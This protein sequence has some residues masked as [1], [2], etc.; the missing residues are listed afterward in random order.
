MKQKIVYLLLFLCSIAYA[1][2]PT[3]GLQAM[4]EFT[5][6]SLVDPVNSN[7]FT[8]NGTALTQVNDR[9]N[10]NTKAISLNGDYLSRVYFQHNQHITYSF[11]VKTTTDTF[12]Y[13]TIIDD[14]QKNGGSNNFASTQKGYSIMLYRGKIIADVRMQHRAKFTSAQAY[15]GTTATSGFIADGNWHHVVVRFRGYKAP[16]TI[17]YY[18]LASVHIDGT[19]HEENDQFYGN[20]GTLPIFEVPGNIV[21]GNNKNNTLNTNLKYT[22]NI[23]D[24]LIYNRELSAQEILNIRDVGGF[25]L[26]PS[27]SLFSNTAITETSITLATPATSHDIAYHKSSEPFSNATIVTQVLNNTT[28]NGLDPSTPYSFY[29]RKP[30][31]ATGTTGWSAVKTIRTAGNI[32]VNHAATGNNDGSSWANAYT[33]LRSSI[34]I[35]GPD[36]PIWVATGTYKPDAT[37]RTIYFNIN[38]ENIKI[39]GGFAGTETAISQRIIGSNETILSG[40]LQGND[41]NVTDYPSNYANSTRNTD[42]SYHI[43]N[44]ASTGNNLLL[45]G[46]TISNAHNNLSGSEKGG[47]IIKD[48]T[49]SKLTLKNCIIKDNVSRNDNAGLIA[50]FELNNIASTRGTLIIDNCKFINNMSRWGSGIY[51]FIRGNTNVDITVTNSL[52]ENNLVADL[53]SSLKGI[54]GSASWFRVVD[55]GSNVTL[56]LTNNTYVNNID[57][58]TDNLNNLNRAVVAISRPSG[59]TGVFNA[60]LNNSIFWGNSTT[61]G[62]TTRSITDLYSTS[63]SSVVV[64]NSIDEL[65][66]NDDSITS[67]T[68][69]NNS[70]PLFT[71]TTDFTLQIGSPAIDTGDNAK[72]VGNTDLLG[73][74]RVFNT[75]V[76]MGAFEY[77]SPIYVERTLTINATNGTVATN[78]NPNNNGA[79]AD[80]TVVTLTA[81]PDTGYQFDGWSGALAGTTNPSNITMDADKTVTATFSLIPAPIPTF[82]NSPT[83][84]SGAYTATIN[85]SNAVS[86]FDISDI[87][88]TGATLSNFTAVSG[89]EYTVVVTPTSIC[90]STVTLQVP[91]NVAQDSNSVNNTVSTVATINTVDNVNPSIIVQNFTLQ[92]DTN[93]QG[94]LTVASIDNGSSDNCAIATR[95]LDKT[96]FTCADL[97]ANT[98]KLT[99]VDTSGNTS[100]ATATVT[101]VDNIAPSVVTQ[102][103]TVQLGTN[104]QVNINTADI[105]NGSSDNCGISTMSLNT[106]TFTCNNLGA[107][108]V[109][110]TVEDA[111]GNTNTATAVVTVNPNPTA[112]LAAVTQ[113]I[114]VQLDVNGN[115]TITPQQVDNGSGSGCNSNPT[116]SLDKTIFTCADLGT[117]TVTLTATD[118]GNSATATA[119]VTIID[120]I[121]PTIIAQDYTLE[122]D[123]N[124]QGTLTVATIDNGSSDNCA[125]ATKTLDKTSFTCADLGTNT[126]KLTVVDTSGNTSDATATVTVV[127]NIAPSVVTQNITVQLGTNGQVNINTADINNGSSDNCGI[128]SMS[129]NTTTFTCNNLGTN[130][131]ILTV[132]DASGNTNTATAVV[133]VNP[134]P[135]AQLAAVTQNITVQLDV[136]GNATITPQQVDNGSGSGCN[137]NPTLSLDKTIFTCADLGTNTVSLTATDGGNS[138]TATAT[139]T[140]ID[141]IAPTIVAQDY[142]LELDA[143]GQGTLTVAFID[144]GSSD[145]CAIATRALDKTSFTCTD[146]GTNTVKLTVV[147][148]SG[149]TSDTTATVTVV[150]NIAPAVIAQNITVQLGANGQVSIN[151]TDI[152]NG[153]SDN[154]GISSMS[155]NTSTFTC[156]NLGANNVVLT[157]EDASGNTNTATAVVT[158]NSNPN[159]QLAAITQNITV[160][161]DANGNAT[162]KPQQIDNGSGSGCNSSPT[163]SLDVSTFS[164]ANIGTN[165]VTLTANDGTTSETATAIVTVEDK[166][167]PTVTTKDVTVTLDVNGQ[168]SITVTDIDNGSADNCGID[169]RTLDVTNFTC[170]D[171]AQHSYFNYC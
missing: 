47:A 73:N 42:N 126:V 25:C 161:L 171:V 94:T 93:G 63:V 102:N 163:L 89:T 140:I 64:N 34:L 38:K 18:G 59:V 98:V 58:G 152:N 17:N 1:Q 88:V 45:D 44:I 56:N 114:T 142:T 155:L 30:C 39:Y 87:Q 62:A 103:I 107:N 167:A 54:S 112:Q 170:A 71:S 101:V 40:D 106:T 141:T 169:T 24:I 65:N 49:I 151:T 110:L 100:D 8:Q 109:T 29:L 120:T 138:A 86:G 79:Y 61:G 11:W 52:F 4:Y 75:T 48:K 156:N 41:T 66:F 35:S 129:L 78:P 168:G 81:T 82:A 105:N 134:N 27:N 117:N 16:G 72:V 116:L 14:S 154:C 28:I 122:L 80:G 159:A 83:N 113:N 76:D 158:V 148:T 157:V 121:A 97:G 20:A 31:V 23:D 33:D 5:N 162:I 26:A 165:T 118:G 108:N 69:T 74:N 12:E 133:T 46:L 50:E 125:I 124:G 115:A 99:V 137:S 147:D 153:S 143:N 15:S 164:C 53:S 123:A 104:G 166:T 68:N 6:G 60:Q 139:V 128:S 160:Q 131:V 150:D 21:L 92:L 36:K 70:D 57:L 55:N 95:T 145:N 7:N 90:A 96:S 130:N 51:S 111:S 146:L 32:Y 132:E 2:I 127:D 77:G 9:L 85:F 3:N 10:N 37:I 84:I 144:N 13:K 19:L 149:N 43:I 91:A 67:A 135:N 136:N 22:E 119:T